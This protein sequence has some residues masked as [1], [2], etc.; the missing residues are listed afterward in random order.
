MRDTN[1][2]IIE[3]NPGLSK[4]GLVYEHSSY[5]G[6]EITRDSDAVKEIGQLL[7]NLLDKSFRS[8]ELEKALITKELNQALGCGSQQYLE[9]FDLSS[10]SNAL[11]VEGGFGTITRYLGEQNNGKGIERIPDQLHK[12]MDKDQFQQYKSRTKTSKVG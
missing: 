4:E 10:L 2:K 12:D 5:K 1:Q 9:A 11:V 3:L 7:G 6:D 8:L